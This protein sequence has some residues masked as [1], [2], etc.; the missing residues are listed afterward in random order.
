MNKHIIFKIIKAILIPFFALSFWCGVAF[1]QSLQDSLFERVVA[2]SD[3]KQTVNN[4]LICD[5]KIGETL[6]FSIK[7]AGGTDT[8]VGFR[9]SDINKG[10]YAVY[11]SDCIVVVPGS[12][13]PKNYDRDYGVYVSPKNGRVYKTRKACQSAK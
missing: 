4:G 3:C 7:D 6:S 8:V 12:A 10:V 5:Y 11:Y 2:G 9:Y 13:H 1:S